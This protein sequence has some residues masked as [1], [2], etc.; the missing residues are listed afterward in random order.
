[1]FWIQ[2]GGFIKNPKVKFG[3]NC[4]GPNIPEISSEEQEIMNNFEC[5]PIES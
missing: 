5:L 3:V 4:Y 1:M 2:N